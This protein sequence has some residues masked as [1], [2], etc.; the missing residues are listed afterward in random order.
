MSYTIKPNP[1]SKYVQV[2]PQAQRKALERNGTKFVTLEVKGKR[3]NGIVVSMNK[4]KGTAQ[5]RT[6]QAT[7]TL[8]MREITQI[9]AQGLI[10]EY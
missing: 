6:A 3:Y 1:N 9:K 2:K 4:R 7:K 5:V 10:M 8:R